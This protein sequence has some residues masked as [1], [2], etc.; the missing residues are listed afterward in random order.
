LV[1]NLTFFSTSYCKK[2]HRRKYLKHEIY[3]IQLDFRH[4]TESVFSS[5]LNVLQQDSFFEMIQ[6]YFFQ[7]FQKQ[8]ISGIESVINSY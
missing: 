2:E 7:Y 1:K 5:I 4:S 6:N 8:N 3:E